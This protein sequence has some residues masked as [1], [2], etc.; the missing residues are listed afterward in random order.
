MFQRNSKDSMG[1]AE[2]GAV[3]VAADEARW[4]AEERGISGYWEVARVLEDALP[5]DLADTM[6]YCWAHSGV[7][8][9]EAAGDGGHLRRLL[10]HA[11]TLRGRHPEIYDA[12]MEAADRTL[13]ARACPAP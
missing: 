7:L 13:E 11:A 6:E 1:A 3:Y 8:T 9:Q 2:Q 5:D 10:C 4:L 12:I